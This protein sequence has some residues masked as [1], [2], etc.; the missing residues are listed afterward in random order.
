MCGIRIP[1]ARD[2]DRYQPLF[3]IDSVVI[4]GRISHVPSP[5]ISVPSGSFDWAAGNPVG[6]IT[7]RGSA[8]ARGRPAPA[9]GRISWRIVAEIS[10]NSA[11]DDCVVP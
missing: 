7:V 11:D 10:P 8:S 1:I 2:A 5:V 6:V 9:S 4:P 3:E